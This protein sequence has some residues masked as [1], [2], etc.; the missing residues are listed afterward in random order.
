MD[1][2]DSRDHTPDVLVGGFGI[3]MGLNEFEPISK[4]GDAGALPA[5]PATDD[6]YR[7]M[8]NGTSPMTGVRVR[9][10]PNLRPLPVRLSEPVLHG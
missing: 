3:S 2:Y 4:V 7:K 9:G 8:A 10:V 5:R 1:R 6:D